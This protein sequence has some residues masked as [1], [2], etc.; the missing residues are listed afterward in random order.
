MSELDRLGMPG[1]AIAT[2]EFRDAAAAQAD[3]MGVRP[4]VVFVDHPIQNRTP[5][6]LA[7]IAD[8]AIRPILATIRSG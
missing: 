7:D 4:A 1:C 8:R 5:E 2:V 3:A 6:E